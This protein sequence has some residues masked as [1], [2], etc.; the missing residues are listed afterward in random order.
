MASSPDPRLNLRLVEQLV[1]A[2]RQ[3]QGNP[4]NEPISDAL[5]K[6]ALQPF[7]EFDDT[8]DDTGPLN[9]YN[10]GCVEC[11]VA[12]DKYGVDRSGGSHIDCSDDPEA[13][14]R[15]YLERPTEVDDAD[16]PRLPRKEV[17]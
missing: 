5:L 9:R 11:S 15:A 17:M 8:D 2:A 6:V 4:L 14:D 10:H 13:D 3:A 12:T 1:D 7:D 16:G